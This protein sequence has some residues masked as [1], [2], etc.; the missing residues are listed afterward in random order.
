MH[1]AEFC[2]LKE[3]EIQEKTRLHEARL[4]VGGL[5]R[6]MFRFEPRV[7]M[8]IRYPARIEA[9]RSLDVPA[10]L[11]R[12]LLV[13]LNEDLLPYGE[14]YES[15]MQGGIINFDGLPRPLH[16]LVSNQQ[17]VMASY[18]TGFVQEYGQTS[19]LDDQLRE[20]IDAEAGLAQ[21]A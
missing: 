6:A 12:L 1:G 13:R 14:P 19:S 20:M 8:A 4:T 15:N 5:Y 9:V 11:A 18:Q 2:T 17:P 7:S 10:G 16:A 21:P 3:F